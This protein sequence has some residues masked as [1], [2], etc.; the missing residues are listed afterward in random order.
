M[1]YKWR[2]SKSAKRAFAQKMQ[3]DPEFAEAYNQRKIERAENRRAGSQFDYQSA[4]GNY[5][6]T[7]IQNDMA[8]YYL[9]HKE[10]TPEQ[11]EACNMVLSGFSLNEKIHHDYIHIVNEMIRSNK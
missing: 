7:K 1:A 4:G 9:R 10:L 2:P 11:S 6:P 8:N 3:N 5:V